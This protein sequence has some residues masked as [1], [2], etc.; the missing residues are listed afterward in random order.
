MKAYNLVLSRFFKASVS[1]TLYECPWHT[2]IESLPI[3]DNAYRT[4]SVNVIIITPPLRNV[5]KNSM[6]PYTC[7]FLVCM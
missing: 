4:C 5:H 6:F 3:S 7:P 2:Y 1:V